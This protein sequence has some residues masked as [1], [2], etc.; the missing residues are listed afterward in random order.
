MWSIFD[1]LWLITWA[2]QVALVI[3]N[4]PANNAGDI[5][6]TCSIPGLE[7][8]LGGGNCRLLQYSCLENPMDRG[9]RWAT[10]YGVAKSQTWLSNWAW[11]CA[12]EYSTVYMYHIFCIHSSAN[13]LLGHFHVLAIVLSWSKHLFGFSVTSYGK[14]WMNFV[15]SPWIALLWT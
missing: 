15:A 5:R 7:R 8:S 10:V 4:L 6:D 2:S 11:T 14:F 12:C 13:G 1:W 3:K 9:A